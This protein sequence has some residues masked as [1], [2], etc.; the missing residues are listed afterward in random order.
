MKLE[1]FLKVHLVVHLRGDE[2][3]SEGQ[4]ARA[5]TSGLNY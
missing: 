2:N 4:V 1:F 5:E 3:G